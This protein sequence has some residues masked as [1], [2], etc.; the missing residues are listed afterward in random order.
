MWGEEGKGGEGKR[1]GRGE[2]RMEFTGEVRSLFLRITL[3]LYQVTFFD[4]SQKLLSCTLCV[5]TN[6]EPQF[7]LIMDANGRS[8][9]FLRCR[10]SA[11]RLQQL[12]STDLRRK[13]LLLCE[14]IA[15][16]RLG[17]LQVHSIYIASL[18]SHSIHPSCPCLL[19]L[20]HLP[21]PL[22]SSPSPILSSPFQVSPLG[23]DEEQDQAGPTTQEQ[24]AHLEHARPTPKQTAY[25]GRARPTQKTTHPDHARPTQRVLH[26]FWYQRVLAYSR[27]PSYWRKLKKVDL[28][29]L[30]D[31]HRE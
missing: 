29:E 1:A 21:S 18:P 12:C 28:L 13:K 22:L 26:D 10:A 9:H 6:T 16:R 8:M 11:A 3:V 25:L 23:L 27:S 15:I 24:T 30:G 7:F 19:L 2:G 31:L 17:T 20:S 14:V 5:C 4:G